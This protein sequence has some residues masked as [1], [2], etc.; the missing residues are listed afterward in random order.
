MILL[1]SVLLCAAA[2][3]RRGS[4]H[5][6][7]RTTLGQMK[8][9]ACIGTIE[10]TAFVYLLHMQSESSRGCLIPRSL[11][12]YSFIL[13]YTQ[14]ITISLS[15]LSPLLISL[16]I[17]LPS[18]HRPLSVPLSPSFSFSLYNPFFSF[19]TPLSLVFFLF[20]TNVSTSR[21]E[22]LLGSSVGIPFS[23]N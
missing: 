22:L 8:T 21:L 5:C 11:L 12:R 18:L 3:P 16:S 19:Y 13:M 15:L 6:G 14:R 23:G 4:E 7:R 10:F 20:S 2:T 17:Y 9:S 1:L